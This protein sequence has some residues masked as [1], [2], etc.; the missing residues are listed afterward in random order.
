[1]GILVGSDTRVVVQGITGAQGSFH[2]KLMQEYGKCIV[3]GTS[4]AKGGS[5]VHGVPVYDTV[6]E[7][8]KIHEVNTSIVFVPA[9]S[10]AEAALE[11]LEA[12]V[13]TVVVITE[14]VPVKDAIALMSYARQTDAKVVG[15]NTPGVISPGKCKVGILPSQEFSEGNVGVA[16]RSGTLTYEIAA[17]LTKAGVGQST[18]VGVGGDPVTGLNL[19]DALE[20]FRHDEETDAVVL[21][22]EI[23]G[24]IEEAAAEYIKMEK[25]PKPVVAYVAGLTAPAGKR[26]GHA[27]A[28]VMGRSGTAESKIAAFEDAGVLVA[29]TPSQVA[30]LLGKSK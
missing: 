2:T 9:P 23:G 11:A 27:G 15:P 7:A 13:K 10:A 17:A 25:Y 28:I 1:M 8:K 16:S 12:G 14:H 24:N 29:K 30:S 22:G 26:M 20:L 4:P 3:A 18:C 5:T 19:I 6:L 21:V